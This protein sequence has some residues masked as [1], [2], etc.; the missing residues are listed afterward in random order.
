MTAKALYYLNWLLIINRE[1]SMQSNKII[2]KNPNIYFR[3]WFMKKNLVIKFFYYFLI[4]PS[5]NLM[6]TKDKKMHKI[7][8]KKLKNLIFQ[9]FILI[10]FSWR[11]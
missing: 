6:H 7:E 4:K 2:N 11:D 3:W 1:K 10:L 9:C 5:D 8:L